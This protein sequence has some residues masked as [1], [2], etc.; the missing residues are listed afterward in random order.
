M[1]KYIYD[2]KNG[3]CY[4]RQGYYYLPC[5][6]LSQEEN[7]PISVWGQRH[8]RYIKQYKRIFYTNML[9]SCKLNSYLAEIDEQAEDMFSRLIKEMAKKQ[10]LT[11]QLKANDQMAWIG[12]MN[13]IRACAREIVERKIIYA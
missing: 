6:E 8:L 3:F 10:G 9:T 1:E 5:L 12:A 4:E 13:N 7:K 2:E 11:E